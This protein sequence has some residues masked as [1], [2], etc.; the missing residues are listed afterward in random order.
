MFS[1]LKGLLMTGIVNIKFTSLISGKEYTI[2]CTLMDKYTNS[3]INQ[4]DSDVIILFRL[5]ED[6]WDDINIRTIVSYEVP[7]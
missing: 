7:N 5:D 6:R 1:E 2:P 3:R 4:S